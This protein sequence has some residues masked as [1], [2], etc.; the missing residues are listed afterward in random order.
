MKAAVPI[1]SDSIDATISMRFAR[2]PYL[3]IID[4][5]SAEFDIIENTY[6]RMTTGA[7]RSIVEFLVTMKQV[8]VIIAYELG[9]NVQQKAIQKKIQLILLGK[10]DI[11]LNQLILLMQQQKTNR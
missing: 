10:K 2:C 8:K 4:P 1:E 7:G 11:T 5:F 6:S 9:L 3:A